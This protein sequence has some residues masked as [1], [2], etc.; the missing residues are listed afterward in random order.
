MAVHPEP[1]APTDKVVILLHESAFRP[2]QLHKM[3]TEAFLGDYA[4]EEAEEPEEGAEE[5]E[6]DDE[7]EFF[8]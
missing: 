5:G 3:I 4:P 1:A 8:D 6:G 2:K 7:V